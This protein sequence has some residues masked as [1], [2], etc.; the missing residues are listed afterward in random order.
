MIFKKN[1][2]SMILALLALSC[3]RASV[4][5]PAPVDIDIPAVM[6][7]TPEWCWLA[8]VEM[9][10]HTRQIHPPRQCEMAE[11]VDRL[12]TNSCCAAPE[13]CS[14]NGGHPVIAQIRTRGATHAVVIRGMRYVRDHSRPHG[15]RPIVIVNDPA[16]GLR[17]M[18][19]DELAAGWMDS[20]IVTR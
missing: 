3:A 16:S 6:Q 10:L 12:P 15:W 18:R 13:S 11:R 7:D 2:L 17:E 20:I 19:Y 1:A 8:V 5:Q 9:I 4:A 14:R